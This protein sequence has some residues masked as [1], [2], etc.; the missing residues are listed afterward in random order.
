MCIHC[1][2]FS[3]EK[4]TEPLPQTLDK[5]NSLESQGNL[6]SD[7][8]NPPNRGKK[9]KKGSTRPKDHKYTKAYKESMTL[10]NFLKEALIGLLLGDVYGVR[11]K[12]THNARLTFDQSE[13]EHS[14]P[15]GGTR[16][17]PGPGGGSAPPGAEYLLYLFSLFEPF[18]GTSPNST[19]RKPDKRTGKVYNSLYFHTLAFPCFNPFVDLFY[20]N[21]VKVVPANIGELLTEVGLAFWIMDDGGYSHGNLFLHTNSYTLEEVQCLVTTLQTKFILQCKETLRRPGQYAI[22]IPKKELHKVRKLVSQYM[23]PSML[24]KLGG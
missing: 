21:G 10:S 1:L 17:G 18:V 8:E 12:P 7:E 23:H 22:C 5:S 24:Y 3:S 4:K 16:R 20:P 14:A 19:D 6:P 11:D 13:A 9:S 15:R 2:L